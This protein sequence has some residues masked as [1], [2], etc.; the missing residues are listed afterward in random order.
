MESTYQ[1]LVTL[2]TVVVLMA[3]TWYLYNEGYMDPVIEKVG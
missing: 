3:V 2:V 1:I